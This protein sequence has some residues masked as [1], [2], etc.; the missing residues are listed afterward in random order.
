MLGETSQKPSAFLLTSLLLLPWLLCTVLLTVD[1]SSW[2]AILLGALAS[3]ASTTYLLRQ[4]GKGQPDESATS[5]T[6]DTLVDTQVLEPLCQAVA[7]QAQQITLHSHQVDG[8]L[9]T[10]IDQLTASFTNLSHL[11]GRQI[12]IAASL[13]DRYS[14]SDASEGGMSFQ[15]FVITTQQTLG[16]FV[17][18]TIETSRTSM[19]LVDSIDRITHKIGEIVKSTSDMDAIAKQT[20]LLAL[21]AAIEAARAGQAGRGFAVVADEVRALS[22]RSSVF[23]EE[24]RTHINIVHKELQQADTAISHLAAK[25]MSFAMTSKKQVQ[26]MLGDLELMNGKTVHAVEELEQVSRAVADDVNTAITAL[27]FQDLSSQLLAQMRK[28]SEQLEHFTLNLEGTAELPQDAQQNHLRAQQHLSNKLHN[29]V[30][31]TSMHAG[32]IDLF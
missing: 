14:D 25:D 23:S 1:F 20:N 15:Q 29:P 11:I 5:A 6:S 17:D 18:S 28:H 8:L 13:T 7:Q 3:L 10:A 22:T 9:N 27:Q 24:I 19:E 21:N 4:A 2:S 12:S 31:Q 26:S 16:L 32:E 30:S